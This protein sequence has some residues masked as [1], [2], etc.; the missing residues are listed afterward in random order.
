MISA[1]LQ[2]ERKLGRPE[3]SWAAPV[4]CQQQLQHAFCDAADWGL[5]LACHLG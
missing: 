5:H 1:Y 4:Q 3:G 2:Q